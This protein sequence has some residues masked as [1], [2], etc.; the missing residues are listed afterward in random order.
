MNHSISASIPG[1]RAIRACA[2]LPTKEQAALL[3]AF[4]II[5]LERI[6]LVST[7]QEAHEAREALSGSRVLG[8]DTES[9]PTFWKGEVSDGPHVVQFSLCDRAYVFQLHQA[10]CREVAA[11]IL[12]SADVTKVGFSLGS[13]REQ[14]LRTLG[15]KLQ[16]VIDLDSIFRR[17][18]YQKNVGVKAAVAMLFQKRFS[19]SK[20]V[21]TSNWANRE[22]SEAQIL[23]AANDAYAAMQVFLA[24]GMGDEVKTGA[25]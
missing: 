13:D 20:K 22:L 11:A 9:K 8:F 19:K 12:A 3:E 5:E 10:D 18:G 14:I 25:I 16:N 17:N 15:V 7:A 23:Y 2:P 4:E 21:S 6:T 24:L 1:Q